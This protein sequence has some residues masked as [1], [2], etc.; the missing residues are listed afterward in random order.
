MPCRECRFFPV[1]LAFYALQGASAGR[2][3]LPHRQVLPVFLCCP[4]RLPAQKIQQNREPGIWPAPCD[5][6]E[7]IIIG[8]PFVRASATSRISSAQVHAAQARDNANK[9]DEASP[10]ALLLGSTAHAPKPSHKDAQDSGEAD[11]KTAGDAKQSA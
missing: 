11:D 8:L 6:I 2:Q 1:L 3:T 9:T 7:R 5:G 4:H 10:F